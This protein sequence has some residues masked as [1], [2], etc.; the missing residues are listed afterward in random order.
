MVEKVTVIF[1]LISL[2]M[3]TPLF[4]QRLPGKGPDTPEIAGFLTSGDTSIV[5]P[6]RVK[7]N[8]A[9]GGRFLDFIP[10]REV[11]ALHASYDTLWIGTEGG[12]FAWDLMTDSVSAIGNFPMNSVRSIT[13][14]DYYRLWV[15]CDEGVCLRDSTWKVYDESVNPFFRRVRDLM[16][17]NR[18]MWIATYGQGCGYLSSNSLT[19]YTEEDSLLDNRVLSITEETASQIW[20]GTASGVCRA[21][22]FRWESI[23]YGRKIPIGAV[24]DLI[25]DENRNLFIAVRQNGLARYKFG[26]T[27]AY[28]AEDGLPGWNLREFSLAPDGRLIAA[29]EGGACYYDGSGWTPL[30]TESISLGGYNFLSVHHDYSGNCFLGSDEGVVVVLG[31]ESARKVMIPQRFPALRVSGIYPEGDQLMLVTEKGL[32]RYGET[33]SAI[34]LPAPW[35]ESAVTGIAMPREGEFWL[36]TRF[37]ALHFREGDWEVYDRRVG[38]PT[39]YLTSVDI[40]ADGEIW[41]GTFDQG[42]LCLKEGKWFVYDEESGLQ[43]NRIS[44]LMVSGGGKVRALTF[45][46]RLISFEGPGWV[47]DTPGG[48]V[49]PGKDREQP[50]LLNF[51]DDPAVR[52]LAESDGMADAAKIGACIGG[53]ADGNC[54]YV[55][56]RDIY[57]NRSGEWMKMSLPDPGVEIIP[58]AVLESSGS[59]LW[60]GTENHGLF[61]FRGG[62]WKHYGLG[63]G[64]SGER[65]LSIAEDSNGTIWIGTASSGLHRYKH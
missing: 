12:L 62:D 44:D 50:S 5:F 40:G 28:G 65:V 35:Y 39:E 18:K 6:E 52:V 22:S 23:R 32:Y 55:D 51:D 58:S 47:D 41:F 29:G 21:D 16:V 49:S 54:L 43:D 36:S 20:F 2:F 61:V 45:P 31:R 30:I 11:R 48:Y 60:L 26:K 14:D 59:E 19:V 10:S 7:R 33:L 56:G 1:V 57:S 24:N 15:G 8:S 46:G 42:V 17:G 34:K 64:F 3:A 4:S 25:F 38:L 13:V 27:T 63:S 53:G 9:G 37:G